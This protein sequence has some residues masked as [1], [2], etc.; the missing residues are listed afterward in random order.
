VQLEEEVEMN[1]QT[2]TQLLENARRELLAMQT[3]E[4]GHADAD[5]DGAFADLSSIDQHP[6]D[7]GTETYERE[8]EATILRMADEGLAE[9]DHAFRRLE[10]GS[11]GTCETCGGAVPDERLEA[12][13]ATRFCETH[14]RAWS[15]D[16]VSDA[17]PGP[18]SLEWPLGD[19]EVEPVV[20]L[21]AEESSLH[22]TA[23]GPL[24]AP[25]A[26]EQMEATEWNDRT[27]VEEADTTERVLHDREVEDVLR[28]E[29][30]LGTELPRR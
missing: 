26:V 14:Q 10:R 3:V 30:Q 4:R 1:R 13:P 25:E 2:A 21:G 16:R 9:I 11:Y 19:D 7:S 27:S 20:E 28:E 18:R 5:D 15:L 6:A 8:K 22:L 24:L 29:E 12:R 23:N 17:P